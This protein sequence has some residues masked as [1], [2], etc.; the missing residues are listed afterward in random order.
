MADK[1]TS[2][3]IASNV[4]ADAANDNFSIDTHLIALMWSEP[5]FSSVL[6]GI[7]KIKAGEG[8]KPLHHNFL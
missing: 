5:F 3:D 6:R 7:E 2:T 8:P 1:G 4:A